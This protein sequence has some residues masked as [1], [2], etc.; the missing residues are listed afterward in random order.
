MAGVVSLRST[1][2][3]LCHSE[4]LDWDRIGMRVVWVGLTHQHPPTQPYRASSSTGALSGTE[5]VAWRALPHTKTQ[6]SLVGPTEECRRVVRVA[7]DATKFLSHRTIHR[8]DR[9]IHR[10]HASVRGHVPHAS[11]T[12]SRIFHAGRA[13]LGC[14]CL[15]V[16]VNMS[17]FVC[18]FSRPKVCVCVSTRVHEGDS[19]KVHK[20]VKSNDVER[21]QFPSKVSTTGVRVLVAHKV[22]FETVRLERSL[23]LLHEL[24]NCNKYCM[25]SMKLW[26]HDRDVTLVYMQISWNRT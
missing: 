13:Q 8:N 1:T 17:F 14:R 9:I 20:T 19:V 10:L 26:Q 25:A 7:G 24:T 11:S 21:I 2:R 15:S 3:V 16:A 6:H 4:Q 5:L 23:V 22:L 18:P 12:C